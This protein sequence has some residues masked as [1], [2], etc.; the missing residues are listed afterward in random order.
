MITE[1][2][3]PLAVDRWVSKR[4]DGGSRLRRDKRETSRLALCQGQPAVVKPVPVC[5]GFRTWLPGVLRSNPYD[6]RFVYLINLAHFPVKGTYCHI[7]TQN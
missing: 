3:A 6:S 5:G 7:N 4:G 1:I 2:A